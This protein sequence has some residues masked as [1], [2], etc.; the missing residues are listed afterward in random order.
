MTVGCTG[1]VI[2]SNYALYVRKNFFAHVNT[3]N[4][5]E[6]DKFSIP[7]LINRNTNDITNATQAFNMTIRLAISAPAMAI[8]GVLKVIFD[9]KNTT[10]GNVAN[11][12]PVIIGAGIGALI[13]LFTVVLIIVL[14]KFK[15]NKIYMDNMNDTARENITGIRVIRAFNS[16]TYHDQKFNVVNNNNRKNDFIL[17]ST[18]NSALP[19]IQSILTFITLGFY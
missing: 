10:G 15:K 18:V 7:S 3:F 11:Y 19:F 9:N 12:F 16:Q 1:A 5:T 14:P 13:V 17:N 6:I 8:G 4:Q 2:S